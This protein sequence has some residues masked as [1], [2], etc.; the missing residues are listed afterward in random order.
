MMKSGSKE[1]KSCHS[2]PIL[3]HHRLSIVL[4]FQRNNK[5]Q[6]ARAFC[7]IIVGLYMVNCNIVPPSFRHHSQTDPVSLDWQKIK[8]KEWK[9]WRS[10]I[11]VLRSVPVLWCFC[12]NV[13]ILVGIQLVFFW[14]LVR[15]G[16]VICHWLWFNDI[17]CPKRW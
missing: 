16:T 17:D 14:K 13:G 7:V 8:K 6:G 3:S 15:F 12:C 9:K 11:Y 2:R 10:E 1:A 4:L 5:L